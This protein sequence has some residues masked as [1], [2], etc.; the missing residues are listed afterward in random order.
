MMNFGKYIVLMGVLI[1][2]P[3]FLFSQPDTSRI[4]S[5]NFIQQ[6]HMKSISVDEVVVSLKV[7]K[8]R[9]LRYAGTVLLEQDIQELATA[10]AGELISK[11]SSANVKS[12]GGLGG[13][14]SVS[15]RAMGSQHTAIVVDGFGTNNS[16]SGQMNLGQ[17]QTDGIISVLCNSGRIGDMYAPVSSTVSGSSVH[18]NTIQS[19][20]RGDSP[21]VRANV[22]YG[23]FNR[24]DAYL[25]ANLTKGKKL[26]FSAFG[27]YRRADGDYKY[28]F[29]NGLTEI[30]GVRKNND[31]EDAYFGGQ[32]RFKGS[33]YQRGRIG[34]KGYSIDQGLPGAVILYNESADERLRTL[35]HTIYGD[36]IWGYK[37]W[38]F[39][40][41]GSANQNDLNYLDPSYLNN[42]GSID[43]NYLNRSATAGITLSRGEYD[44]ISLAG[45]FEEGVSSLVS[46]DSSL[47]NPIRYHT[48]AYLGASK[49]FFQNEINLLVTGQ[50]VNE[51][52]RLSATS[53]DMFKINP[54]LSFTS[55]ELR[56]FNYKHRFWY[57]NTFRMPTFNELYYNQVGNTELLPETAHQ[58]NYG[59]E[60]IPIEKDGND[61]F[62]RS[63]IYFN[64][65]NNKIVAIPTKNLFVWSMQNVTNVNIY[66]AELICNYDRKF[67]KINMNISSNYSYQKAIDVTEE[68]LNF[69]DQIAYTPE[70]LANLDV[71]IKR[72]SF[73]FRFSNNFVSGRYALNENVESNL[74]KSYLTSD[75]SVNYFL[76]LKNKH[77]L[78]IQ[79][80]V[81]NVFNQSYAYV[82]SFVMPGRN[83]LISLSY[84]LN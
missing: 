6:D 45:G 63:N 35:D 51:S 1:V 54:M 76:K 42:I 83:Y 23:S 9:R 32:I 58:L 7:M 79:A 28:Q 68:S 72:N 74:V 30:D 56:K 48:Q 29:L 53:N 27:K 31:Y 50:Y 69:G 25:G 46:S 17:I 52:A 12:Y 64:R 78:K 38:D 67:K 4:D 65:V 11:V 16:Q 34:Y 18:I 24:Q 21:I 73:G 84:A 33:K 60:F 71:S 26:S 66:G 20:Y 75:V 77:T 8:I 81:K 39:R 62:I 22:S 3:H 10:D 59:I 40:T 14:K 5:T 82:R 36:F 19:A 43:V 44:K 57:K 47:S 70:H 13:M 61:L 37:K 2:L 41:Y 15:I 49:Y 55:K 80:N